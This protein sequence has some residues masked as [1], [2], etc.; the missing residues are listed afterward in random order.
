[1]LGE[2]LVRSIQESVR[3]PFKQSME[4]YLMK[5]LTANAVVAAIGLVWGATA[6]AG[7]ITSPATDAAAT[8]YAV[9]GL[10][11][12]T[13][14]TGPAVVYTMGVSRTTA[15]DFTII[16]TPSAG[17]VFT[18]GYCSA[19]VPVIAGAGAGTASVKRASTTECAYEID[20]TTAT[21]TATTVTFAAPVFDS[22]TLATSGNTISVSL[23]LWDLGETARIDN[24][25]AVSR[26]VAVSGNALTLTAT[27]DTATQANVNDTSGPLFGFVAGGAAPVDTVTNAVAQFVVGNN[28]A[29]VTY[30]KPDGTTNW[31]FN[32]VLDGT[33]IAV[34]VTG[35]YAQ[36]A[37]AAGSF[38]ASSSQGGA[39][40][41]PVVS[42]GTATFSIPPANVTAAPANTTITTTFTTAR[43]AS[44]GTA[45]T[46]GVSAVGD[47]VTGADVA[48]AGNNSWWVWGANASQLMTPYFTVNAQFTS[49]FW[50]LNT[51]SSAV[52]YS[53]DCLSETGST[54]VYGASR[55]GTLTANGLTSV[56]ASSICTFT[57]SPRGAIIF[58]VNAPINTV[59]GSYQY[60]DPITLNGV[61][62][63]LTRPYNQANT[64]E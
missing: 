51:G 17:A 14:I 8:A 20:V 56:T 45:R 52:T 63:P 38:A 61:V 64:T 44:M 59:K 29:A 42:G 3:F 22:H 6:F 19:V 34:T 46:F 23:N 48:L 35:N 15:Q 39:L 10:I 28:S 33:S 40:T 57:G 43:T 21:T 4:S 9:E 31:D 24:N 32:N 55:T 47:V 2:R 50:L 41:N 26:R 58:T 37:A 60:I 7:S 36:L 12:T 30:K 53:A 18:A 5:K 25:A 49:R 11:N 1:M 27:Q 16:L 13:D 54:P 62:T